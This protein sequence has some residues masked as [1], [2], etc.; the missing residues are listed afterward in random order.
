MSVAEIQEKIAALAEKL[1]TLHGE[2]NKR[3]KKRVLANLGKLKKQLSEKEMNP[4]TSTVAS[5]KVGEEVQTSDEAQDF[6]S[7]TLSSKK[8]LKAKLHLVNKEL[9]EY[10]QK[11]QLKSAIKTFNK[12][13]KKGIPLDVHSY[14]NLTN[15][16]VRCGEIDAAME[17]LEIMKK[18]NISPNIVLLTTIMKG[19]CES[20]DMV[21]AKGILEQMLSSNMVEKKPNIRTYNTFLRGCIRVGDINSA[22][23]YFTL[24][25]RKESEVAPDK[26]TYQYIIQLLCQGLRYEEAK[27][28]LSNY[29]L[30]NDEEDVTDSVATYISLAR[31]GILLCQ[32]VEAGKWLDIAKTFLHEAQHAPLRNAM[33]LQAK[34]GSIARDSNKRKRENNISLFKQHQH[35]EMESEIEL[36]TQF[37]QCMDN[38]RVFSPEEIQLEFLKYHI[39]SLSKLLYF[40]YNSLGSTS[41]A[42]SLTNKDINPKSH[43]GADGCDVKS[44]K[45]LNK[46]LVHSLIEKFGLNQLS[47]MYQELSVSSGVSAE[48]TTR[49]TADTMTAIMRSLDSTPALSFDN[50]FDRKVSNP[51][52]EIQ[53]EQMHRVKLEIGAGSGDWIVDHAIASLGLNR[54]PVKAI[55]ESQQVVE[56][57]GE[58]HKDTHVRRFNRFDKLRQRLV[59]KETM[60]LKQEAT[61]NSGDTDAAD[62]E[63]TKEVTEVE[64]EEVVPVET[65]ADHKLLNGDVSIDWVSLELRC[66]RVYAT[67]VQN[68]LRKFMYMYKQS[69]NAPTSAIVD[70]NSTLSD[71][72]IE[73]VKQPKLDAISYHNLLMLGGDANSILRKYIPSN[74]ISHI[75]VNHPE[76]PERTGLYKDNHNRRKRN[77]DGDDDSDDESSGVINWSSGRHLLTSNFFKLMHQILTNETAATSSSNGLITIVTD[78]KQ[79]ALQLGHEIWSYNRM[80]RANGSSDAL[81]SVYIDNIGTTNNK[82][83]QESNV[84]S[85][86]RL[87]GNTKKNEQCIVTDPA[88]TDA[89]TCS[90]E[91]IHIYQ[92]D[93]ISPLINE[94]LTNAQSSAL[95]DHHS[96]SSSSYFDRMWNLG[97]IKKR[98]F[99]YVQKK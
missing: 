96:V 1:T 45:K 44:K 92:G 36:C 74:S 32:F 79:Y 94:R 6:G 14:A 60:A 93:P 28:V 12:S 27:S 57:R 17:Q 76:P 15:A 9:A 85:L 51:D 91:C 67:F 39:Q 86:Y 33:Q 46:S 58:K 31:C 18:R 8:Q 55:E 70:E 48:Q 24:I 41:D 89:S 88:T 42:N 99:I 98:W 37:I 16:Y 73:S 25:K 3:I 43:A 72:D 65:S 56:R 68:L 75:F 53:S 38:I 84:R 61:K 2:E 10:A 87:V 23:H 50:I 19:Y 21:S 63:T 26:T 90:D 64:E 35:N 62:D 83:N 49:D 22:L 82:Y 69:G 34:S 4:E 47:K 54:P 30:C 13:M 7:R 81:V 5:A 80:E 40:E 95:K 59:Y 20:G 29:T 77:S 52:S 11:K 97:Q 78:N 66:D 71:K